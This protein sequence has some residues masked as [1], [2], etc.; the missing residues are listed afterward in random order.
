MIMS[1]LLFFETF[2]KPNQGLAFRLLLLN[3]F[4]PLLLAMIAY[5]PILN[6]IERNYVHVDEVN[7]VDEADEGAIYPDLTRREREVFDL[8]LND[9]S[10][11]EIAEKLFIAET[12][13]KKHMQNILKKIECSNREQ[14]IKKY[15]K[16]LFKDKN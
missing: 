7:E 5:L 2:T 11:K 8:A 15:H 14:L 6:M 16:L 1:V 4:K 3:S 9:L 13:V 12:T 10:N